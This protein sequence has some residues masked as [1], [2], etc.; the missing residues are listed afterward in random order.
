MYVN[1]VGKKVAPPFI[2]LWW[3]FQLFLP[4]LNSRCAD[5]VYLLWTG[6]YLPNI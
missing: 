1:E 3:R 5:P 6:T 4:T 2:P